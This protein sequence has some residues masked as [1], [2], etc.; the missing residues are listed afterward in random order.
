MPEIWL[1]YGEVD[2]V[3]DVRAENLGDQISGKKERLDSEQLTERLGALDL[4]KPTEIV[5]LGVTPAVK[6]AIGAIYAMCETKSLPF[7]K[8][9]A[10]KNIAAQAGAM[11]PEGAQISEFNEGEIR[12]NLAF[13]GEAGLDGLFGYE[14][15]ATRLL[16]RFGGT[17]M[18]DAYTKRADNTP[19][20]GQQTACLEEAR[21]FASQFDITAIELVSSGNGVGEVAIGNPSETTS[22]AF[23]LG[24]PQ[25]VEP[26]RAMIVSPG[27]TTSCSTLSRALHSLWSTTS[28]V[29]D[30][31]LVVLLAECGHG[32]GSETLQKFV[33]DQMT[34]ERTKRPPT[35]MDGMEDLLYL[36]E[37]R[38]RI[39]IALVST[40]PVYYTKK[41]GITSLDSAK[42]ALEH[43]LAKGPRQKIAIVEKGSNTLF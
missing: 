6:E 13:I 30:G 28:G 37:A 27:N 26:H 12:S 22:A 41:L 31:G 39:A 35:Y 7:P 25:H 15:I 23:T 14:T 42:H 2:I 4:S 38:Q 10:E 40:L 17:R 1:R 3:L 20:P 8:V 29:T 34:V 43:V 11:L 36:S 19:H 5:V 33:E 9:L 21:S 32:M 16:R 24:S 18:H